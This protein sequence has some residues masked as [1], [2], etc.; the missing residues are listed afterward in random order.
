MVQTDSHVTK[1]QEALDHAE[2][3]VREAGAQAFRAGD[4]VAAGKARDVVDGLK[5]LRSRMN[6]QTPANNP[7]PTVASQPKKTPSRAGKRKKAKARKGKRGDY[8]RYEVRNNN[9]VRVGWSKKD[10]AEYQHRT[11]RTIFDRTVKAMN[12][13]AQS[14]PGPFMAEKIIEKSNDKEGPVPSYQAYVVIGLLRDRKCVEQVGRE[15]YVI[16]EDVSARAMRVWEQLEG[17]TK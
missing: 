12:K 14:G 2:E 15:G 13:V 10:K 3:E 7:P 16:P 6:G 11:P 17:K 4:D 8:P 9:L 1:I 5:A